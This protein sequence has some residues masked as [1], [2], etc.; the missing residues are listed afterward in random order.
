VQLLNL[1]PGVRLFA[2]DDSL[3]PVRLVDESEDDAA[4]IEQALEQG[5]G[6][7]EVVA[8]LTALDEQERQLRRIALLPTVSVD[9]G[10]GALG[11]GVGGT[12]RNF[13][14]YTDVAMSVQWD[15]MKI[16]GT[17]HTRD[18]F[19]SKRRQASLQHQQLRGKLAAGIVVAQQGA[20]AAR[21]RIELAESEIRLAIQNYELGDAR[22]R[23]A[24]AV[25]FEVQQAISSLGMAR[26]NYLDAVID[27]NRFQI[28]LQFLVGHP[29][30]P[31][32][33]MSRTP[34]ETNPDGKSDDPAGERRQHKK[35]RFSKFRRPALPPVGW[36]T[37][38]RPTDSAT[39][40]D[41]AEPKEMEEAQTAAA[42]SEGNP[43]GQSDSQS[44]SATKAERQVR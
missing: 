9:V 13:N 14:D 30:A 26:R 16:M 1:E 7:A 22:L 10:E 18:L 6:L 44:A 29:E 34:A 3:A 24:E 23:A 31:P 17:K 43:A 38:E 36:A 8:A 28:Q 39:T 42:P 25:I 41:T 19:E 4:L 20:K 33:R 27:Y 35:P 5:P 12:H 37:I 40:V 21:E 11:G 15:V 2:A 32:P